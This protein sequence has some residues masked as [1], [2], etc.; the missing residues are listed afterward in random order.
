MRCKI[1]GLPNKSVVVDD[2]GIHIFEKKTEKHL[3]FSDVVSVEL[4]APGA[5]GK[6]G[7]IFFSTAESRP[8]KTLFYDKTI[9]PKYVAFRGEINYSNA[10]SIRDEIIRRKSTKPADEPTPIQAHVTPAQPVN[11][12]DE[13]K[14]YKELLD[15]G[16]ITQDEYDAK[17]KQ[18]LNL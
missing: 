11:V 18:L 13:I 17:K 8:T 12:V 14:R 3:N 16:A 6:A 4:Q 15:I 7:Y 5:L 1:D 9:D 10:V 2:N